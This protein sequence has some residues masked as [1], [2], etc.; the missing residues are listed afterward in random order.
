MFRKIKN[1][2]GCIWPILH[3]FFLEKYWDPSNLCAAFG[4]AKKKSSS[5]ADMIPADWAAETEKWKNVVE[6]EG[7]S[8]TM[9]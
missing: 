9:T 3:N 6:L 8:C 4:D 1:I 5:T 7:I 2:F